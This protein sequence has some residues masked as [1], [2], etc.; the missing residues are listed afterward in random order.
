MAFLISAFFLKS[1]F[2]KV[3]PQVAHDLAAHCFGFLTNPMCESC[4][5][6][7]YLVGMGDYG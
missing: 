5:S 3:L 6:N 7:S 1:L 2:L 4:T